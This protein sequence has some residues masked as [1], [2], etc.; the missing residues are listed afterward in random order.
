MITIRVTSIAI[1]RVR[2]HYSARSLAERDK[3]S[4]TI[5]ERDYSDRKGRVKRRL[6][7]ARTIVIIRLALC[8]YSRVVD[9]KLYVYEYIMDLKLLLQKNH[10]T[11]TTNKHEQRKGNVYAGKLLPDTS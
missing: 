4:R 7:K 8:L 1:S 11:N 6:L 3:E 2:S 9:I 10:K 5:D